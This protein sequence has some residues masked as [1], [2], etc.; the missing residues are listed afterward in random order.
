MLRDA[1]RTRSSFVLVAALACLSF[2][3]FGNPARADLF[4]GNIL[5]FQV[6]DTNQGST[7]PQNFLVNDTSIN[8]PPEIIFG[9]G[10]I[11]TGTLT[12][13][14]HQMYF[15]YTQT[16]LFD[17]ATFNGSIIREVSPNIPPITS[18]TI[19]KLSTFAGLSQSRVTFDSTGIFINVSGLTVHAGNVLLLD[20]NQAAIPEPSP[21]TL[22][23]A[24]GLASG[25]FAW[26]R[27]R[28][29]R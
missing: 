13:T 17:T 5:S 8:D 21:L 1:L 22:I 20:V 9:G 25:A 3:A 16:A 11:D 15:Q 29:G 6:K 26:V 27:R 10:N 2:T 28:A 18:V 19:D 4:F 12:V 7:V 23:A 24:A 14:D